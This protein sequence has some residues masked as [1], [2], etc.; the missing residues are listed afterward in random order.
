MRSFVLAVVSCLSLATMI[1]AQPPQGPGGNFE[2]RKAEILKRIDE[3][4]NRLQQMKACIQAAHTRDD[5]RSCMDKFG[6]KDRRQKNMGKRMS[7]ED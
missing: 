6:M 2:A 7:P 1:N 4:M 3:R 5:F